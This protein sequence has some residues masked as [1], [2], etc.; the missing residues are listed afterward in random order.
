MSDSLS[1]TPHKVSAPAYQA[2]DTSPGEQMVLRG[3]TPENMGMLYGL[4]LNQ[5]AIGGEAQDRYS[6]QLYDVN[7]QQERISNAKLESDRLEG[8]RKLAIAGVQYGGADVSAMT[9]FREVTADPN[10]VI[11]TDNLRRQQTGA[12]AF[13]KM[14]TGLNQASEAGVNIVPGQAP[15]LSASG[16]AG[17]RTQTGVTRDERVAGINAA[18]HAS[19]SGSQPR[20]E[21]SG[22]AVGAPTLTVRDPDIGRGLQTFQRGQA[23]LRD[24]HRG[25]VTSTPTDPTQSNPGG[26]SRT[27]PAGT[28]GAAGQTGRQ[29]GATDIGDARRRVSAMGLPPTTRI[30][31]QVSPSGARAFGYIDAQGKTQPIR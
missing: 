14:S 21:L 8:L 15:Q 4:L 17:L 10:Q 28:G 25:Q 27:G 26:G 18:G 30:V 13:Q 11:Q 31:E 16:L 22:G 29:V 20:T 23:A 12:D 2:Y 5:R 7:R 1:S 24:L 6:R 3:I 19:G 9:P